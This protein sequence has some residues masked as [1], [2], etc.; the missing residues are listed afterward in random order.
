MNPSRP[1]TTWIGLGN[2]GAQYAGTRHNMGFMVLDAYAK[3]HG[4]N[5][6]KTRFGELALVE[7]VR[8]LK[9]LTFMN[10]SGNAV[11]PFL[12]Y[13]RLTP[14]EMLIVA[15]DLDLPLGTLRIRPS[16]GSGG[17][18]GLKSIMACLKT[19]AFARL[20]LG[21]SRPPAEMGVVDWVLGRWAKSDEPLLAE[22]TMRAT[23]ALAVIRDQGLADAMNRFN[24]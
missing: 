8:L 23:E 9:P 3:A 7:G 6:R 2:P 17:H 15:D 18:N 21:I 5:F 12:Q 13:F 11:C 16:G 22:V 10:L 1:I 19:E 4:A 20:R 14:E 24:G